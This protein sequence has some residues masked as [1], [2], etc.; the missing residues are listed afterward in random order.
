MTKPKSTN[1]KWHIGHVD[2]KER[3]RLLE[4]KGLTIWFTGLPSSGKSTTAFMVEHALIHRGRM[5]Y[6][7]DGDNIRHGLNR[8]LGFSAEDR[9]ENIRRIGEVAKLFA[10]AGMVVMTSFISPYR[11]DRNSVRRSHQEAGLDFVE[12]YI[13][14]SVDECAKRDPKGLY[15]KA[16]AGEIKGFTGVDDPYEPPEKPELILDTEKFTR[17]E[18]RDQ[19][20]NYLIEH[21][22]IGPERKI[23]G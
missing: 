23:N 6:V 13:K 11:E 21:K 7:L 4:Q 8:N 1:I 14:A 3:Q 16:M 2:R 22:Y 18:C 19:L 12:V 5:A 9:K 15:K 17:E 20:I 10:D